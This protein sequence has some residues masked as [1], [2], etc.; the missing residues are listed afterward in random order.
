MIGREMQAHPRTP[1]QEMESEELRLAIQRAVQELPP[2]RRE[3][4][5]LFHLHHLSYREIEEML[6]IRHQTIANHLQA[7]VAELRSALA[8]FISTGKGTTGP[9][10]SSAEDD[11]ESTS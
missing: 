10:C 6:N 2:R 1:L 3:V 7:A 11:V 5:I 8:P 4:F 9:R